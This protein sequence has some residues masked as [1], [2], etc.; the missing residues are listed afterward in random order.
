MHSKTTPPVVIAAGSSS[1]SKHPAAGLKPIACHDGSCHWTAMCP[2]GD[3]NCRN[4]SDVYC[5]RPPPGCGAKPFHC[6][7]G[8]VV[9][10][11]AG[12]D[13]MS[14]CAPSD[15]HSRA[16]E[17]QKVAHHFVDIDD[18][19]FW[20]AGSSAEHRAPSRGPSSAAVCCGAFAPDVAAC[21]LR[22]ALG[23]G[24]G[25]AAC[26]DVPGGDLAGQECRNK[27]SA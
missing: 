14:A 18:H 8:T 24:A 16:P 15:T 1:G 7:D 10:C 9:P 13:C 21:C 2:R 27:W 22:V 5:T 6:P 3:G 20:T 26:A 4:S 17:P 19:A 11:H 25:V 12:T 23:D